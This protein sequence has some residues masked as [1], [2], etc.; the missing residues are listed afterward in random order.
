MTVT[1]RATPVVKAPVQSAPSSERVPRRHLRAPIL[2]VTTSQ[3]YELERG[4]LVF[5]R[6]PDAHV[7]LQDQLVSRLHARLVVNQDGLV[8][9]EDLHSTNGVYVNGAR[10]SRPSLLLGE[11][12]RFLIGTTELSVFAVRSTAR[13]P[14]EPQGAP[15]PPTP[16]A[17]PAPDLARVELKRRPRP[18]LIRPLATTGRADAVGL[19][20]QCAERLMDSGHP[21]EAIRVLSEHLQ[22]LKKGASAGLRVPAHILESATRYALLAHRWTQQA[23]WINYV[24][25]LHLISGQV[26]NEECVNELES[27]WNTT[28]NLDTSVLNHLVETLE[29]RAV[30]LTVEEVRS[31]QR[32]ERL[33]RVSL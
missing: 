29:H 5:G 4:E 15:V 18:S 8:T 32:L 11:G 22:N 24:F 7:V 30:P 12:D 17:L 20:G 25:E 19:V 27:A 6:A 1:P 9:I 26:P 2:V 21:L 13:K 16:N 23:A 33:G 14:R 10:L 3:E 28:T 31:L